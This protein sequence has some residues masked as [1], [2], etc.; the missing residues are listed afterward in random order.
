M[1][2]VCFERMKVYKKEWN[3]FIPRPMEEVWEFFSRPENLN[4]VTPKEMNFEILSDIANKPMYEGMIINYKV[5]PLLGIKM[6]WTTEIQRIKEGKYFVDEQRFGPYAMWHHEH[7]FEE[8]DGG[9]YMTDL[10][11]YAIGFGP[12]GNLANWLIVD[13][14]ID[15]IFNYR[16]EAVEKLF[17]K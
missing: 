1:N 17:G 8:K 9:V 10:L 5:T 6:R 2:C 7:H 3:Q 14:K 12:V 15:E 11:H 13:N 16:F 4:E